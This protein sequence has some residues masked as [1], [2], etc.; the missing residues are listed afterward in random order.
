MGRVGGWGV[1]PDGEWGVGPDAGRGVRGTTGSA[2][3]GS[4]R[5]AQGRDM[6]MR[7]PSTPRQPPV[8]AA[9]CSITL[10]RRVR[11]RSLSATD[12]GSAQAGGGFGGGSGGGVEGG[13]SALR[14]GLRSLAGGRDS[15]QS[16]M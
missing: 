11:G 1:G 9:P 16:D 8:L 4:P 12:R 2:R 10:C 14:G 5:C 13:S 3:S 6:R 7:G 15:H